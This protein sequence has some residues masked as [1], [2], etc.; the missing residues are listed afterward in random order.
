MNTEVSF[1]VNMSHGVINRVVEDIEI[2]VI[3]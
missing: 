3:H 1:G 2:K